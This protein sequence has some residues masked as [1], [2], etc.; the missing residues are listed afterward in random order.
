MSMDHEQMITWDLLSNLSV[1]KGLT[2]SKDAYEGYIL[3]KK[4]VF[5]FPEKGV[6]NYSKN[7]DS[8]W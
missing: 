4:S 6:F 8:P 2:C 3:L 1:S 5:L 7:I